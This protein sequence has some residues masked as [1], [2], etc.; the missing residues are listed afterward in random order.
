MSVMRPV[1]LS[2]ARNSTIKNVAMKVP[3]TR[4]M[5]RRF[6]A[7]ETIDEAV[8]AVRTLAGFG[9]NTTIDCLGEDTRD[10]AQAEAVTDQ[11]VQ[12]LRR[13][14]DEQ[15]TA[16]AEVSVKLSAVGQFLG[17]DGERLA[18]D[19]AR[20]ICGVAA[21]VGTT[22]TLDM[23]DHTTVDS[24]LRNLGQLRAGFGFV[25][26]VMQAYLYRTEDDVK[27]LASAGSRVRLCKGAYDEP[28]EVAYRE[29]LEVDLSYVRCLRALME[30]EG[31]P[32][33]ATHDPRLVDI[34]EDLALRNH[35][36]AGDFEFQMLYGVR[37]EEQ[38]RLAAAGHKVRVYLPYGTDW[39]GYFVRRLAER[40]ANML[41][42]MRALSGQG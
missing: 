22:V 3:V 19:N 8:A 31:Y 2:V 38:R 12:L 21:E 7:G 37:P 32:M 30:S 42:L 34:A 27:A 35:R 1:L 29:K 15:L 20:R 25:G 14:A 33:V 17:D 23:E 9:I 10:V 4:N 18:L 40:P 11:Y 24:T 16:V 26:C 5:V 28:A 39:Y 41:F 36:A 13:L 6:V